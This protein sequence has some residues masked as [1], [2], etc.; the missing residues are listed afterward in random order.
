MTPRGIQSPSHNLRQQLIVH[1]HLVVLFGLA[2]LSQAKPC[3][4]KQV[5]F[6]HSGII[7]PRSLSFSLT[8]PV[9]GV[10]LEAL[11]P[12]WCHCWFRSLPRTGLGGHTAVVVVNAPGLILGISTIFP[13][14]IF[15]PIFSAANE[16]KIGQQRPKYFDLAPPVLASEKWKSHWW[17]TR[18]SNSS[19]KIWAIR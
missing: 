7:V 17:L 4:A 19:K 2:E 10:M 16:K 12:S 1:F 13:L 6:T 3:Q 18:Y 15:R 5:N 9:F 8:L 11:H 14:E